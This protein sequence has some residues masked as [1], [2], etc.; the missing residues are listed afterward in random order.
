MRCMV[1]GVDR[2]LAAKVRP[3]SHQRRRCGTCGRRS[4]LFDQGRWPPA[5]HLL[6]VAEGAGHLP[7]GPTGKEVKLGLRPAGHL[8]HDRDGHGQPR[9]GRH[10]RVCRAPCP[11]SPCPRLTPRAGSRW[12]R[13]VRPAPSSAA[14]ACGQQRLH[15]RPLPRRLVRHRRHRPGGHSRSRRGRIRR[16]RIINVAGSRVDPPEVE[17]ALLG[18]P[19]VREAAVAG[20]QRDTGTEEVWASL[21]ASGGPRADQVR[22]SLAACLSRAEPPRH[23]VLVERLPRTATGKVRLGELLASAGRLDDA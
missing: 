3:A 15:A 8:R 14:P 13:A 12:D 10:G 21:V 9:P 18:L 4:R 19:G 11:A 1:E 16:G 22:R 17:L 2:S 7:V 5:W 23:L 6:L 20:R